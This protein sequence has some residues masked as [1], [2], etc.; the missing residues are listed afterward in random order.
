MW[1]D[2]E[3]EKQRF[4]ELHARRE[5]SMTEL[6]RLFGVSRQAGY[7][8]IRRVEELGAA[9][10]VPRDRRPHCSPS[11][12]S[13]ELVA[14]IIEARRLHRFWGPRKLRD[15]LVRHDS[16]TPWPARST[17]G[18]ILKRHGF[19]D[20]KRRR[21]NFP[22]PERKPC[23]RATAP[24]DVWSID[25]KGWFRLQTGERCDPLTITDNFSRF[26]LGCFALEQPRL[27]LVRPA[28][29]KVFRRH[30]LPIRMRSD[31]G[32]PFAGKG[33]GG[34]SRLAVWL[35]KIGV[36]PEW[37]TPGRPQE[38]GRHERFH[39]TLKQE[40]ANPSRANFAAQKRAFSTFVSEFNYDRP[41]EALGGKCPADVHQ[42]SPR[43]FPERIGVYDYPGP[44]IV[45]SVRTRGAVKWK[46]D[47]LFLTEAL[48]GERVAL[49]EMEQD[50]LLVRFRDYDVGVLNERTKQFRAIT[51]EDRE[52]KVSPMSPDIL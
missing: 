34:L 49:Y 52:P 18:D 8:L 37:I 50:S 51:R 26:C 28:L 31:N 40:T 9:A 1:K 7:E 38:N 16:Q 2:A 46:G 36:S 20:A 10:F 13:P 47:L 24:N 5:L 6:C 17:F 44:C 43:A 4:V 29:V 33:I 45:R 23:V 32:P 25:F 12:T 35:M 41:H 27:E 39:R 11:A 22:G 19:V 42:K 3:A 21:R 30:G 48:A 14:R 15:W